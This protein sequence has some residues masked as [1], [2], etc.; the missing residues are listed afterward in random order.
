MLTRRFF[1]AGAGVPLLSEAVSD[2]V[3][4]ASVPGGQENCSLN[5]AWL[6]RLDPDQKGEAQG[7]AA[8]EAPAAGWRCVRVPHTW[9]VDAVSIQN[10][11]Y[12]YSPLECAREKCH[13]AF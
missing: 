2:A 8:T 13:R 7:W 9:Q 3:Q 12:S 10:R 5:G 6:F 4:A 1:L 11:E